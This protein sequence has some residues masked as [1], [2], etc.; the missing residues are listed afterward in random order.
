MSST[1]PTNPPVLHILRLFRVRV[2][3]DGMPSYRY[4]AR[5][6]HSFDAWSAAMDRAIEVCNTT[7]VRIEVEATEKSGLA[8]TY[9]FGGC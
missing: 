8:A 2:E 6:R 1:S 4:T 7:P 5:A 9:N 3:R